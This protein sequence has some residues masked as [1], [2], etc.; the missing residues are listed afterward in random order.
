MLTSGKSGEVY[1]KHLKS[2][3]TPVAEEEELRRG[4][5]GVDSIEDFA[6]Q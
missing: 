2:L 3:V 4:N 5:V 6:L 1:C